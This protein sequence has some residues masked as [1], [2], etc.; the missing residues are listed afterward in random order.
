MEIGMSMVLQ[1]G[2]Y[3]DMVDIP[4][5]FPTC[6]RSF[7]NIEESVQQSSSEN[8]KIGVVFILLLYFSILRLVWDQ[9]CV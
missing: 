3:S 1:V 9:V 5:N 2:N 7:Y 6:G 8:H 4:P